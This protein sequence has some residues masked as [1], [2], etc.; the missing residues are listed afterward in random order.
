MKKAIWIISMLFLGIIVNAQGDSL[1]TIDKPLKPFDFSFETGTSFITARNVGNSGMVYFAP[2][3]KVNASPNLTFNLKTFIFQPTYSNMGNLHDGENTYAY[4]PRQG[5]SFYAE[6]EYMV[7]ERLHIRGMA[8]KNENRGFNLMHN[9]NEPLY[10]NSIYNHIQSV[11]S[12]GMYYNL[13][14]NIQVGAEFRTIKYTFPN[15]FL[16]Y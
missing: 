4:S 12:I 5:I 1:H 7:T 2:G 16:N 10:Y 11:Y 9:F 8:M 15:Y 14:E 13:T 3:L 6:G